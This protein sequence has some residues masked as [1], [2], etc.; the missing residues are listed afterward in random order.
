ML[1]TDKQFESI[2]ENSKKSLN[3][4]ACCESINCTL[5]L[6]PATPGGALVKI[7]IGMLVS[8]FGVEIYENVIFLGFAKLASFF[9]G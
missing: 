3:L 9:W 6:H 4:R 1:F 8:F 2:D 7:L 5:F